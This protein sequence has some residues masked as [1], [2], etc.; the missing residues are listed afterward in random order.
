MRS[1]QLSI[2]SAT[3][4]SECECRTVVGVDRGAEAP[5][6]PTC[7]TDVAWS[8][9]RSTYVAPTDSPA[10]PQPSQPQHQAGS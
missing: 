9:V 4:R 5:P 7:G 8:F 10:A 6:C 2:A 1:G 3:Y